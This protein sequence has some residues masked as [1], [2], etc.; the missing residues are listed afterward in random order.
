MGNLCD[1]RMVRI[2][3]AGGLEIKLVA[4]RRDSHS[5]SLGVQL[6]GQSGP[7]LGISWKIHESTMFV[8]KSILK[9]ISQQYLFNT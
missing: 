9:V 4:R 7:I 8:L 3:V 5:A 6:K 2:S 1:P